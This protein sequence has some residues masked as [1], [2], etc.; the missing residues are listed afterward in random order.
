MLTGFALFVHTHDELGDVCESSLGDSRTT[1][2]DAMQTGALAEWNF[3]AAAA[4]AAHDQDSDNGTMHSGFSDATTQHS[5]V[6]DN[7][8]MRTVAFDDD[9]STLDF[10][11][12]PEVPMTGTNLNATEPLRT[13][14]DALEQNLS[15]QHKHGLR[16]TE[17]QRERE[18]ELESLHRDYELERE[19]EEAAGLKR[20]EGE[21]RQLSSV[22]HASIGDFSH[23]LLSDIVL[24]ASHDNLLR[25]LATCAQVSRAWHRVA[26]DSVAYG[27]GL[28]GEKRSPVL[29]AIA[30]ALDRSYITD[31]PEIRLDLQSESEWG[32]SMGDDGMAVLVAALQVMPSIPYNSVDMTGNSLSPA[33][34][35]MFA[36]T[37]HQLAWAHGTGLRAL[38]LNNNYELGDD[39]LIT[40]ACAIPHTLHLLDVDDCMFGTEGLIALTQALPA[41]LVILR[42]GGSNA[43]PRACIAL[44]N[45]LPSLPALES[46]DLWFSWDLIDSAAAVALAM[47][48]PHCRCL[49]F[50]NL[51]NCCANLDDQHKS[52]LQALARPITHPAGELK[53]DTSDSVRRQA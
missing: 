25:Y 47:A 19:R 9:S 35:K 11:D 41:D 20:K 16:V 15:Q 5:D 1:R 12:V 30:T 8:S 46:L 50:L 10:D 44:A 23:E 37:L 4:Q 18:T 22:P 36:P 40:L 27:L 49:N 17:R 28:A 48:V 7:D 43:G 2:L 21:L 33:G 39:G 29:R 14:L 34:M 26:R 52:M 32:C 51:Y 53:V 45:A 13:P 24:G 6:S 38:R 42:C 3:V 31:L